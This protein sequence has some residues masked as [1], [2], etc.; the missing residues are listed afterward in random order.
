MIEKKME[1]RIK[2]LGTDNGHEFVEKEFLKFCAKEG[3]TTHR[4]C[5]GRPQQNELSERMN[6]T[7]Y[8]C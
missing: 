7:L 2:K 6:K 5:V 1:P 4:T 3:I 8:V